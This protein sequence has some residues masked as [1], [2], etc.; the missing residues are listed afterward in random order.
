MHINFNY[1]DRDIV[2][3]LHPKLAKQQNIPHD[4][5]SRHLYTKKTFYDLENMEKALSF[6]NKD[7]IICDCGAMIGNH[8]VFFSP[9]VKKVYSI[10]PFPE[11]FKLL[12]QNITGNKLTNVIPLNYLISDSIKKYTPIFKSEHKGCVSFVESQNGSFLSSTLDSLIQEQI[13]LL[14]IDIEGAELNLLKGA[15][16]IL[17]HNPIIFLEMHYC[18]EDATYKEIIN[19]LSEYNYIRNKNLFVDDKWDTKHAKQTD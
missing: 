10:E 2:F 17:S 11:S 7:S 13:H 5:L 14:K 4:G 1:K 19:L 3:Y 8:S 12:Q 15:K 9:Y 18:K 6:L 16:N